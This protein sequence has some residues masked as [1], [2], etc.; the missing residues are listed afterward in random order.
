MGPIGVVLVHGTRASRTMWLRQLEALAQ[1]RVPAVAPDLPGHGRR[2]GEPFTLDGAVAAVEEAAASLAGDVVVA[3]L[4][5]GGYLALH[6][7]ART[8][9]PVAAVVAAGCTTR[10]RG[11]GLAA[12]RR[13]AALIG[14]A[15]GGGRRLND[16]LVRLMLP[17][18]ARRDLHAGGM[19]LGVMD[20][21]LAAVAD[22]DPLADLRALA[23]VPVHLVNGRWDHFRLEERRFLATR[24]DAR[25]HVVPRA[26]HLVSLVRPEEFNRILF[27]VVADVS[28]RSVRSRDPGS[29]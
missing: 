17:D 21:V 9:R 11:P 23:G 25:L 7:A 6:W 29:G 3:G 22:L 18:R 20:A 24:P 27:D 10:P 5:L 26:H 19:E 2:A 4:S 16:T 8:E 12:Y 15:P 1:A 28:P 14:R 13:L